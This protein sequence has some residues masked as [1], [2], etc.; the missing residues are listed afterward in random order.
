MGKLNDMIDNMNFVFVVI[1]YLMGSSEIPSTAFFV[2]FSIF[3][4]S[5]AFKLFL[6]RA[7]QVY[8]ERMIERIDKAAEDKVKTGKEAAA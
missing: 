5:V 2:F 4:A 7:R 8:M 6:M 3:I 1:L